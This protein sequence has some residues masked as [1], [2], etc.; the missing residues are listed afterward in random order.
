MS[1]RVAHIRGKKRGVVWSDNLILLEIGG[2]PAGYAYW[3]FKGTHQINPA[4]VTV[5]TPT[6]FRVHHRA[7]TDGSVEWLPKGTF[8]L[9]AADADQSATYKVAGPSGL[10]L[11]SYF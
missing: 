10:T 9:N 3:H 6:S 7:W 1:Q 2:S 11:Y 4:T 5:V 8:N